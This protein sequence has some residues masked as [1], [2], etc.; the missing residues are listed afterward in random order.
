MTFDEWQSQLMHDVGKAGE[1]ALHYV[2]EVILRE[3]YDA[4]VSPTV[5]AIKEHLR[6][7]DK[8]PS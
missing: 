8:N 7:Y 1:R 5:K 4:G 2:P 6:T 3:F